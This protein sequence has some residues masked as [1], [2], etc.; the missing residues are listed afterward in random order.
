MEEQAWRRRLADVA[1]DE[2]NGI[3]VKAESQNQR[4]AFR[5]S[6]RP[7]GGKDGTHLDLAQVGVEDGRDLGG[8]E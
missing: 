2:Q 7:D 6:R 5:R 3:T 1:C 8:S 4:A